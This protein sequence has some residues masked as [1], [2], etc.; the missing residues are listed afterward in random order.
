MTCARSGQNRFFNLSRFQSHPVFGHYGV[1]QCD[2][3][4]GM[5]E[6]RTASKPRRFLPESRVPSGPAWYHKSLDR[7]AISRFATLG[8]YQ[9][10]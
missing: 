5:S 6:V 9:D 2:I 3:R 1:A 7:I 4:R 10:A 8:G